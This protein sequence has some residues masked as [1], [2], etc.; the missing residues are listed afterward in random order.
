MHHQ[1][2]ISTVRKCRR[3]GPTQSCALQNKGFWNPGKIQF[4][5]TDLVLG[6][7]EAKPIFATKPGLHLLAT[8]GGNLWLASDQSAADAMHGIRSSRR[9]DAL[10]CAAQDL[11]N[12]KEISQ[13]G[14]R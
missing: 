8:Q 12:I 2:G 13:E 10:H 4:R 11:A 5:A 7:A 1:N 6:G 14:N 3:K 9:D